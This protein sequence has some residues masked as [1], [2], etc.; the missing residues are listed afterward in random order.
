MTGIGG[1]GGGGGSHIA[2]VAEFCGWAI[3]RATVLSGHDELSRRSTPRFRG[4]L[5]RS[6]PDG[7]RKN[8]YPVRTSGQFEILVNFC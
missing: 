7:R 2:P 5:F 4:G 3:G 1:R 8:K 6:L